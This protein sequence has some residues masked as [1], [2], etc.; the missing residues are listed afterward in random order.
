MKTVIYQIIVYHLQY[1]SVQSIRGTSGYFH[2]WIETY[3]EV[4]G[5]DFLSL[6][7][8][9]NIKQVMNL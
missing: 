9:V 5:T 1:Y 8:A 6:A 7:G 3:S 4:T 2:L